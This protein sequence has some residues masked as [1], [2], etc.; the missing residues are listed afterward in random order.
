MNLE[1]TQFNHHQIG[2]TSLCA[3]RGGWVSP[4][5]LIKAE[6]TKSPAKSPQLIG[7]ECK[8]TQEN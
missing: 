2:K 4:W 6:G 5:E 8:D 1:E 3:G 7:V